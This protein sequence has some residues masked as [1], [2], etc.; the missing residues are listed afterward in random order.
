M[1]GPE[2]KIQKKI[3]NYLE[4]EEGAYIVKVV[5]ATKAGVPDILCCI[6]G[7]FLAIEVKTPATSKNVSPLQRWNLD[8]IEEAKGYSLVAWDLPMVKAFLRESLI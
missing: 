2:S 5:S 8:R 7:K 6:R 3:V 4:Q 1:A